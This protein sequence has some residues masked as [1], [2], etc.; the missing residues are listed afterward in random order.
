[1]ARSKSA[2]FAP[3]YAVENRKHGSPQFAF[4]VDADAEAAGL[5]FREAK[6]LAC[7][8]DTMPI[9]TAPME[10][11][12]KRRVPVEKR[13]CIMALGDPWAVGEAELPRQVEV[14]GPLMGALLSWHLTGPLFRG[15]IANGTLT[16]VPALPEPAA[17]AA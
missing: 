6:R 14:P 2:T 13:V 4:P 5:A 12:P 17:V 11:E 15:L 16:C 1:M 7:M 10:G 8:F 3:Y 9:G